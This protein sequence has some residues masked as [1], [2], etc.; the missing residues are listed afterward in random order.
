MSTRFSIVENKVW[1]NDVT[2]QRASIYGAVPYHSQKEAE[3]WKMVTNGYSVTDM[4]D[5]IGC[6]GGRVFSTKGEAEQKMKSLNE[7]FSIQ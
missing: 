3:N 6:V 4:V 1:E 7:L 5:N 2:G